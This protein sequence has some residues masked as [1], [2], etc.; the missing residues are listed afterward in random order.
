MP[1]RVEHTHINKQI[2]TE[3]RKVFYCMTTSFFMIFFKA[4]VRMHRFLAITALNPTI[5][6]TH[7]ATS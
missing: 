5:F 4:I 1:H 7:N 3:R 2:K 6:L